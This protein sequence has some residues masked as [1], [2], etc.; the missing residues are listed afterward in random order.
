MKKINFKFRISRLRICVLILGVL[1]AT[2]PTSASF[3]ER[4]YSVTFY[5]LL[6][7]YLTSLTNQFQFALFDLL[8]G[9]LVGGFVVWWVFRL[10]RAERGRRWRAALSMIANTA[11]IVAMMYLA[12]LLTWGLNYR[13]QPLKEKLDFRESLITEEALLDLAKLSVVR[14][15]HLY[16]I[17]ADV[18]WPS[19]DQIPVVFTPAFLRA[20]HRLPGARILITGRPKRSFF[21]FYFRRAAVDGMINPFFLEILINDEV[22]PFERHFIVAHEWA[23]LAGYANESEANFV[24]FLT[25]LSGDVRARYSG[26][27]FLIQ[28]ILRNLSEEELRTVSASLRVGPR[29]DLDAIMI[30]LENST[31]LVRRS[32][33]RVYDRFLK[34]NRVTAGVASYDAVIE[35]VLGTDLQPEL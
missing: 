22:L 31:P 10:S 16:D 20:Q 14:L 34:A 35:L 23:H 24:G 28:P 30:R 7:R 33:R 3:V 25:C 26:W 13:R 15:N 19:L 27:L 12:F 21:S 17:T 9:A 32:M 2:I 8:I 6:Q 11:A 29:E 1:A 4:A 5:P 18:D